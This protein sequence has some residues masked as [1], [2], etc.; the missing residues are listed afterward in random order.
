[1][2][3]KLTR[4]AWP[5]LFALTLLFPV[6]GQTPKSAVMNV[7]ATAADK[8]WDLPATIRLEVTGPGTKR[9]TGSNGKLVVQSLAG[10]HCLTAPLSI[11][12]IP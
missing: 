9:F 3:R 10:S 7:A 8:Q 4:A 2:K 5:C 1:M 11:R 6:L 12:A